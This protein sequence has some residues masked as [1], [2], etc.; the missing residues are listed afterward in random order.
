[1]VLDQTE[2]EWVCVDPDCGLF[3]PVRTGPR[4]EDRPNPPNPLVPTDGRYDGF[5]WFGPEDLGPNGE[6]PRDLVE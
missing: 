6:D 4:R 3:E 2:T 5:G 1:M